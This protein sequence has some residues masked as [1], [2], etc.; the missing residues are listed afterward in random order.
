MN[1]WTEGRWWRVRVWD[2]DKGWTVWCE[3]SNEEE[4]RVAWDDAKEQFKGQPIEFQRLME[5]IDRKWEDRD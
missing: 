5:R 1:G 3:T 2:N 4:A